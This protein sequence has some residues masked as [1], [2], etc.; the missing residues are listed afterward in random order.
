VTVRRFICVCVCVHSPERVMYQ[1]HCVVFNVFRLRALIILCAAC[2][3]HSD[4]M[5]GMDI[6]HDEVP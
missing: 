4:D 6:L 3:L 2:C 5:L 1:L